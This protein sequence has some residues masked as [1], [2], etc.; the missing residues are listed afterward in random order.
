MLKLDTRWRRAILAA[1]ALTVVTTST[2]HQDVFARALR[3][4]HWVGSWATA[5]QG[6]VGAPAQYRNHTHRL[7]VRTSVGG[8]HV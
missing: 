4:V 1:A 8:N 5:V 6:V 7:I 3:E 2:L